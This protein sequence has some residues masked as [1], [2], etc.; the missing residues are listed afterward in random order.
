ML[1]SSV[2]RQ[3]R[4]GDYFNWIEIVNSSLVLLLTFQLKAK[5]VFG[6]ISCICLHAKTKDSMYNTHFNF[7]SFFSGKKA[8]IIHG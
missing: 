7:R 2:V 6:L 5:I 3:K 1:C 4:K 8:R